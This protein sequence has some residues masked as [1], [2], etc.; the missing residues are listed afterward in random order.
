[1]DDFSAIKIHCCGDRIITA[2]LDED[3]NFWRNREVAHPFPP[4]RHQTLIRGRMWACRLYRYS[5]TSAYGEGTRFLI[6]PKPAI[7]VRMDSQRYEHYSLS[8]C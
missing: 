5:I 2:F 1:M 7:G 6:M 3:S 8:I 4:R